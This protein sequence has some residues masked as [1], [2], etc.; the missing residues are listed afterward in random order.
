[1][2]FLQSLAQQFAGKPIDW[3]E[4]EEALIRADLGVAMTTRII[5]TLQEREAWSVLGIGDVIKAVRVEIAQILAAQ[6]KPIRR[7]NDKPTVILIVGVNG[8]GKTTSTAK[9]A[10]Y[11]QAGAI[12]HNRPAEVMLAAADTFR[13]AAIEQLGVWAERLGVEIIRGQYGGDPAALC[14][15]AY[16]AAAKRRIDFLLCDTAGRQHTKTNLMG[17]L[18]KVKR[19]ISKLDPNAPQET[20]LVVDATTGGNTLSQAREFHNALTLTGLIVTKLDG[21]GKGGIVVAIQDELGIP[22]RF[23]GTGERIDDFAPFDRQ[24]YIEDLV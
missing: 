18:Q 20:L 3:D 6:P 19:A 10:H 24:K 1:M 5:K 9:L 17:E 8:T 2:K 12:D 14:Y 13:A 15:E 7:V 22:T 23:V 21:S 16:E 11:L 4:L